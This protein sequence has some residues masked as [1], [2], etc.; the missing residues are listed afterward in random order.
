MWIRSRHDKG[1][2]LSSFGSFLPGFLK[3]D[4]A[5]TA[6]QITRKCRIRGKEGFLGV[7]GARGSLFTLPPHPSMSHQATLK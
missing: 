6:I 4:M 1:C 3:A 7:T 2:F 5:R